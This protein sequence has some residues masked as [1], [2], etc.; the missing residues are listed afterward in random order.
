MNDP[1]KQNYEAEAPTLVVSQGASTPAPSGSSDPKATT[2]A[3]AET[4]NG[5]SDAATIIDVGAPTLPATAGAG[6]FAEGMTLPPGAAVRVEEI[7]EIA[8]SGGALLQPG[9]VFA[10]RYQIIKILGEGGMGAVYKARDVELE[11]RRVTPP[12][13]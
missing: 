7:S 3:P 13:S 10:N 11:Q 2:A 9:S 8:L 1:K 12:G 6:R 4:F 5:S